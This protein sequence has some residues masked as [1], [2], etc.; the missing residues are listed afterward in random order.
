MELSE[1]LAQANALLKEVR[2]DIDNGA[3]LSRGDVER[4]EKITQ[5][6]RSLRDYA[7]FNDPSP[8]NVASKRWNLT[9]ARICQIRSM[10]PPAIFEQLR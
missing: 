7:I 1:K 9:K 4:L 6:V 10:G 3:T 5:M 2:N 8:L